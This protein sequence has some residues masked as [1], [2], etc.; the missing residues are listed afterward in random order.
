MR[1]LRLFAAGL[2]V[3]SLGI[4]LPSSADAKLLRL[5]IASKQDYGSFR[6]GEFVMW[7]GRVVG[8]LRPTEKIPDLD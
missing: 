4:G 7:E 8:E 2:T 1:P 6:P 5:E 3:L